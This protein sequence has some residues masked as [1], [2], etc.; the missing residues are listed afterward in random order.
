MSTLRAR[1]FITIKWFYIATIFIDQE[2]SAFSWDIAV[3]PMWTSQICDPRWC[4]SSY[5]FFLSW[6]INTQ[7]W[8]PATSLLFD[9]DN[10]YDAKDWTVDDYQFSQ[11]AAKNWL[12]GAASALIPRTIF[13][14]KK[15]AV[16]L[17]N[18][19]HVMLVFPMIHNTPGGQIGIHHFRTPKVKKWTLAIKHSCPSTTINITRQ[20]GSVLVVTP[21]NLGQICS[22]TMPVGRRISYERTQIQVWH[23]A[24]SVPSATI[25][26]QWQEHPTESLTIYFD[27]EANTTESLSFFVCYETWDRYRIIKQV[28]SEF[29]GPQVPNNRTPYA[30]ASSVSKMQSVSGWCWFMLSLLYIVPLIP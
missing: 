19:Y 7:L 17:W 3:Q 5:A 27:P 9:G 22:I 23:E 29:H 26:G 1:C 11:V 20:I 4:S 18:Y 12:D 16:G 30:Y 8:P 2:V 28:Q 15:N 6:D 21:C 10:I 13:S 14:I 25:Q 24:R